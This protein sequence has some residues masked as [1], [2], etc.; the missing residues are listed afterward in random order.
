MTLYGLWLIWPCLILSL[1]PPS[2]EWVCSQLRE[3]SDWQ[4]QQAQAEQL[5]GAD[6]G[7]SGV[8]GI[9]VVALGCGACNPEMGFLASL[10][11][12]LTVGSLRSIPCIRCI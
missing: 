3:L 8:L 9:K 4:Q 11:Q 6:F 1:P 7:A 10:T 5:R 12:N 2:L